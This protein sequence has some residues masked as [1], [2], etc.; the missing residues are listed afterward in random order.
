MKGSIGVHMGLRS[1]APP[2]LRQVKQTVM[3]TKTAKLRLAWMDYYQAK[4]PTDKPHVERFI[5]TLEQKC[6]QWGGVATDI[7]DQQDVVNQR[8]KK[9]HSYCPYQSLN[10][11]TPDEYQAKLNK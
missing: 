6:L 1:I 8:L 11:L 4:T 10:Y 3:L 2:P 5:G 7:R 9:Y